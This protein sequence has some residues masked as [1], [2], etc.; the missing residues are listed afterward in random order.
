MTQETI[1]EGDKPVGNEAAI[2]NAASGT[3][4]TEQEDNALLGALVGEGK[5]YK[6]VSEL[7]KAYINADGFIETLKQENHTLRE[8]ATQAKTIDEVLERLQSRTGQ[9][10]DPVASSDNTPVSVTDIAK[11]VEQTIEGRETASKRDGNIRKADAKMKEV[12]GEKAAE[13][14]KQAATTPELHEA[15]MKL[16]AVDPDKFVGLFAPNVP[17]N[18]TQMDRSTL[19]SAAINVQPGN[20][21]NIVGAKEY[22][23]KIRRTDPSKYYSQEFQIG[24]DKA[25]RNNPDFYYGR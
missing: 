23:D 1:F 15:Y 9:Q 22:F 10:P 19:N 11:I 14:Y 12:F 21:E 4:A 7:A 5:K 20:R 17:K 16:A 3:P 13:V 6:S 24:M 2:P 8:K 25:V 18:T